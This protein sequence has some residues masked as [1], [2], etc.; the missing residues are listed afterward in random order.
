MSLFVLLSTCRCRDRCRGRCRG[1][2]CD[3]VVSSRVLVFLSSC[4]GPCRHV[5]CSCCRL[6]SRSSCRGRLVGVV[7]SSCCRRVV[8][9]WFLSLCV[10]PCHYVFT[11]KEKDE[12]RAR[13]KWRE[14]RGTNSLNSVLASY[15]ECTATAKSGSFN[16]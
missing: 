2:Y 9:W 12:E 16:D 5:V 7:F 6:M 15:D 3:V 4:G 14:G 10:G 8:V 11:E 1:R 13:K